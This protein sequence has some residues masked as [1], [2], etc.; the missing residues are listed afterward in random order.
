MPMSRDS[1]L[2]IL[3][4][5]DESAV[6]GVVKMMLQYD[7]HQVETADSGQ[8]ALALLEK[9]KFDLVITDYTMPGMNGDKLAVAVKKISPNLPIIM[10]TAHAAMLESS[11]NPLTGVD[12]LISK[13][14][15]LED[16]RQ[17]IAKVSTK[18]EADKK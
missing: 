1:G 15:L 4:V 10:L 8:N 17:A 3:V 13:P 6:C 14:F 16:L 11:G 2:R 9:S 12:C 18:L 5:D 7:G